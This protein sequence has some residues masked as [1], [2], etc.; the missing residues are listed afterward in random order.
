MAKKASKID[1]L[2]EL[3]QDE[4]I[5]NVLIV[6]LTTILTPIMEK[7][8]KKLITE[9]SAALSKQIEVGTRATIAAMEEI[10]K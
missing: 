9:Q 6:P 7:I 4:K 8:F 5:I 1:E 2:A 10:R 3:I